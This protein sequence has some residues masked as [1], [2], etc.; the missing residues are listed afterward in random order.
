MGVQAYCVKSKHFDKVLGRRQRSPG[1]DNSVLFLP[2]PG[3]KVLL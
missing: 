2:K 3:N 1:V